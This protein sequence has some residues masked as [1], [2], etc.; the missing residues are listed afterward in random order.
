[1][2]SPSKL[3]SG[4]NFHF[5]ET[6][7]KPAWEDVRNK[8]GG[9]WTVVL[10]KRSARGRGNEGGDESPVDKNWLNLVSEL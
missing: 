8:A 7:V 2:I 4:S 3:A 9:K 6:G 10:K 5:F 1:M